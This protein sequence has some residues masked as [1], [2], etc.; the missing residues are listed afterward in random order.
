MH[1]VL[2]AQQN[3]DWQSADGTIEEAKK[4]RGE[5][6]YPPGTSLMTT[7]TELEAMVTAGTLSIDQMHEV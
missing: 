6:A 7:A 2:A 3:E 1:E 5:Y 4:R